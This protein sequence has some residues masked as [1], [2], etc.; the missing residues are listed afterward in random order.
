MSETQGPDPKSNAESGQSAAAAT[1]PRRA[2]KPKN[3]PPQPLPPWKVLLHNDPINEIPFVIRTITE[4]TPLNQQEAT[5]RT[6]EVDKSGV[7]LLLTTH[8][9]RAELYKEQFE[10]KGLNVSIEP[11]A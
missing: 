9:E 11:A 6:H 7:A 3:K 8:R 4:L 1:K 2:S 5:L 10:T